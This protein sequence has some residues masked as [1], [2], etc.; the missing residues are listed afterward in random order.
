MHEGVDTPMRILVIEDDVDIQVIAKFALEVGGRF[1][2]FTAD[3]GRLGLEQARTI[4]PDVIL[5][6]ATMPGLDGYETCRQLKLDPVTCP[7]P[8]IFLSARAQETEIA[9]AR[10]LGAIGYLIKPFDPMKLPDEVQRLL[11]EKG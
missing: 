11:A 9:R 3:N 6:D 5:L 4:R 2:V 7:I 8:V 1:E 10:A